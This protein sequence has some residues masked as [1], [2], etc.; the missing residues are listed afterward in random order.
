MDSKKQILISRNY[1]VDVS[2]S[3]AEKFA[4]HMQ[5]C[6]AVPNCSGEGLSHR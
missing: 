5:L 2:K 4:I 3:Q 1:R 6:L